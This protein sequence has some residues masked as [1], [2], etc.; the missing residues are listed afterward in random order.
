MA[1]WRNSFKS[2]YLASWDIDTPVTLTI[3]SV[4][5]KVIQLQKSEQKV[6]AKFVEKKFPNGEPV[7]EMILNSTNCKVIH[8]ATKNK[9]TDSWKNIKVEI[10]VV[11][12][13]GRIGNEFGL[14]IL[15][16]ISSEDNVLNAKSELVNG[17]AN[18]DKVVA[19][20]KE[21]KQIGLSSIINNLQSKY[22]IST[23]VKKELSQYVD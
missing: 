9:D 19:Y 15:R 14:S 2:D 16:V 3:E 6:V 4:A 11:P 7:K 10:G 17:D 20:V 21:N 12:N 8:K 22:I 23:N 1:N 13:K 5:Q 18:W